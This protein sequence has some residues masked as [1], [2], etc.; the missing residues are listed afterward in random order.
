MRRERKITDKP[1][2]WSVVGVALCLTLITVIGCSASVDSNDPTPQPVPANKAELCRIVGLD[3]NADVACQRG[4]VRPLLEAA[5][6]LGTA[7]IA[8][9]QKSLAPYLVYAAPIDGGGTLE[10]YAVLPGLLGPVHAN[11][12]FDSSGILVHITI[13]D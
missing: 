7:T 8:E 11:F 1:V 3:P 2:A 6:P 13:E 12:S 9:V 5:F 4:G 10:I